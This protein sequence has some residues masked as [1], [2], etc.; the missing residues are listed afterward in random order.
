VKTAY[1]QNV[2]HHDMIL[3]GGAEI[4]R[5]AYPLHMIREN[6]I[7]GFLRCRTEEMDGELLFCY[8]ITSMQTLQSVMESQEVDA[9]LLRM[10]FLLIP[11]AMETL[12][13]YLL[14]P[15]GL[16]LSP[17]MIYL[18][19]ERD[20]MRFCYYPG[21]EAGL[22]ES[23]QQLGEGILPRLDHKDREAVVLGYAFYQKCCDQTEEVPVDFFRNMVRETGPE[24]P[25]E[26]HEEAEEEQRRQE[27]IVNAFF[28]EDD[29]KAKNNGRRKSGKKKDGKKFAFF[30]KFR[31][32]EPEYESL[33]WEVPEQ[34]A[35][36]WEDSKQD[37]PGPKEFGRWK[38]GHGKRQISDGWREHAAIADDD[39]YFPGSDEINPA[40]RKTAPGR[41]KKSYGTMTSAYSGKSKAYSAKSDSG[42]TPEYVNEQ[43][44]ATV[45]DSYTGQR[46]FSAG[47]E[48]CEYDEE[49]ETQILKAFSAGGDGPVPAKLVYVGSARK[50]T[51]VF[52]QPGQ[53]FALHQLMYVIGKSSRAADVVLP[54]PAVSR[55]HARIVWVSSEDDHNVMSDFRVRADRDTDS[56]KGYVLRDLHSK[57]GTAVNGQLLN[58]DEEMPLHDGDEILFAD[59]IFRYIIED[60]QE[61]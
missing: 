9:V 49:A 15:Q 26:Q 7:P 54:S 29:R 19:Q 50:N 32:K 13:E 51:Q 2:D 31:R 56:W 48:P 12:E 23:L 18:N 22:T 27:E 11:D 21:A 3:S 6:A 61:K 5:N 1:R 58:P 10:L 42:E 40:D 39:A 37:V 41:K 4:D 44:F 36:R 28:E 33:S 14:D 38:S 52:L 46:N 17:D 43:A 55:S 35:Q 47:R 20:Q 16:L 30:Q 60:M 53:E 45:G 25:A 34:E 8:D 57:N 24:D 59:L